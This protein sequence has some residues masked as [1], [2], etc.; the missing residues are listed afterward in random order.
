MNTIKDNHTALQKSGQKILTARK[1]EDLAVRLC[2]LVMSEA[3]A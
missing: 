2:V 1:T 3:A